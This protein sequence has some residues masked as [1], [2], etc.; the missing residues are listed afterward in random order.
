MS[1]L[2]IASYMADSVN[3]GGQLEGVRWKVQEAES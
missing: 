1:A 2:A 3:R